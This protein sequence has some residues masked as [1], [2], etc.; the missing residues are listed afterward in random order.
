MIK[1]LAT[2]AR[3]GSPAQMTDAAPVIYID[4]TDWWI[5]YYRGPNHNYICVLPTVVFR[6]RRQ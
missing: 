1:H 5:G 2:L 3:K 6:W 4:T